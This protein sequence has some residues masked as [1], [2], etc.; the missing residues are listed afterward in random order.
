EVMTVS[1]ATGCSVLAVEVDH[2][3]LAKQVRRAEC[4][5]AGCVRAE[6]G[7]GLSGSQGH[8]FS[9]QCMGRQ[10]SITASRL[11]SSQ[12]SRNCSRSQL[13]WVLTGMAMVSVRL[14]I[15]VPVCWAM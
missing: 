15:G 1:G 11:S 14:S 12:K 2:P 4:L 7:K 3:L 10:G 5:I 8:G 9:S 6:V 13:S